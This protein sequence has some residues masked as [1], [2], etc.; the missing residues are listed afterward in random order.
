MLWS[1]GSFSSGDTWRVGATGKTA[2]NPASVATNGAGVAAPPG[3]VVAVVG[4]VVTVGG[5]AAGG[6]WGQAARRFAGAR[7]APRARLHRLGGPFCRPT[8]RVSPHG[9]GPRRA[10]LRLAGGDGYDKV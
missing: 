3:L 7:S 1:V 8:R 9:G 5:V 4:T 10:S 2:L 6:P